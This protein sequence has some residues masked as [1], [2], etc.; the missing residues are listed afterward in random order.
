M[1]AHRV[2][3]SAVSVL[4]VC[5]DCVPS[6]SAACLC[7]S[8]LLAVSGLII[9]QL[10]TV[11]S[12]TLYLYILRYTIHIPTYQISIYCT[13]R[14]TYT[15]TVHRDILYILTLCI[16]YIY[17]LYRHAQYILSDNTLYVLYIHCTYTDIIYIYTI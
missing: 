6:S 11:S 12:C 4:A 7:I 15:Y 3:L 14:Y 13:Y 5:P 17:I 2:Q 8:R 1:C 9:C 10:S 16:L